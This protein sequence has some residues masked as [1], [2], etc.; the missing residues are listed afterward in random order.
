LVERL[1]KRLRG[2]RVIMITLTVDRKRY[3]SPWEA[4]QSIRRRRVVPRAISA[5]GARWGLETNGQWFSK[6]ELQ[7][8]GW[9]HWHVLLVVPHELR[10]SRSAMNEDWGEGFSNVIGTVSL[11]YLAKY[12]AKGTTEDLKDTLDASG[13]PALGVHWTSAARG[14]WG[15]GSTARSRSEDPGGTRP[16][17]PRTPNGVGDRVAF[18]ASDTSLDFLVLDGTGATGRIRIPVRFDGAHSDLTKFGWIHTV[19]RRGRTWWRATME[20]VENVLE[21][22][23]PPEWFAHNGESLSLRL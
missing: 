14:F 11:R 21:W 12:V 2:E 3:A 5:F 22:T 13:F 15:A 4:Y 1:T 18:C 7:R 8:D 9:P 16:E 23:L 17:D 6:L 19:W 10:S 20:A